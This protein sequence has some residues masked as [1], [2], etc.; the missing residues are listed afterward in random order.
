MV[1]KLSINNLQVEEMEVLI[2]LRKFFTIFLFICQ[3]SYMHSE[4][5][6]I[7]LTQITALD[8]I[9]DISV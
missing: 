9:I 5:C 2:L 7:N 6:P 8:Y 4:F 3:T 1:L